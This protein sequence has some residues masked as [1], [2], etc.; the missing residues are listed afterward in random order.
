MDPAAQR[1]SQWLSTFF[2]SPPATQCAAP[3]SQQRKAP[4]RL[5]PLELNLVCVGRKGLGKTTALDTLFGVSADTTGVVT[6]RTQL[7]HNDDQEAEIVL[8]VTDGPGFADDAD[9]QGQVQQLLGS[10]RGGMREHAFAQK[11]LSHH[12]PD[13]A[14]RDPRTHLVL[15]FVPPGELPETDRKAIDTLLPYANVAVVA[16][17]ADSLVPEELVKYKEEIS[18]Q[19]DDS[20]ARRRRRRE[21]L[22]V[23]VDEDYMPFGIVMDDPRSCPVASPVFAVIGK[24]RYYHGWGSRGTA[25][26]ADSDST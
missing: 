20:S 13:G 4:R 8:H 2:L 9:A 17:K 18:R 6:H 26:P 21:G 19:L 7:C 14:V 15:Y 10:I 1:L 16:A 24:E 23:T 25:T 11:M 22:G 12:H 5:A 3:S